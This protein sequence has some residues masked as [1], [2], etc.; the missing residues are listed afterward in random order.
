[1]T[2]RDASEDILPLFLESAEKCGFKLALR[3]Q[4]PALW[5]RALDQSAFIPV[6][7]T[8]KVLRYQLAYLAPGSGEILDFSVVL[9]HENEPAGV[10]PLFLQFANEWQFRSHEGNLLPPLFVSGLSSRTEKAMTNACLDLLE[11]LGQSIKASRS[12]RSS[13]FFRNAFGTSQWHHSWMTRGASLDVGH[14]LYVDLSLDLTQIKS[15]LRKSYRSLITSGEKLWRVAI[16]R[17]TDPAIWTEFRLLHQHVAG[18]ETRSIATWDLQAQAI[19]DGSAFLVYLRDE[20]AR[21]VGGGYFNL[22]RDEGVY[23]VGAYDRSLF[24]KPLGHVVQWHAIQEMK[25]RGLRWYRIGPRPYPGDKSAPT[26]KELAIAEFKDGF[27]THTFLS[28]HAS[29]NL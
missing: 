23:G 25:A 9:L 21:M 17:D 12:W 13:E 26:Q 3:R 24:A 10:W 27:A 4:Q 29:L 19:S 18:R 8:E 7:Y 2:I 5:Q 11:L 22:S 28:L 16:L 6:A 14:D 15:T 1:M 20:H